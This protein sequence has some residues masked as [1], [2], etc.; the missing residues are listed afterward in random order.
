MTQIEHQEDV[1][2]TPHVSKTVLALT[3]ESNCE[4]LGTVFPKLLNNNYK[5]VLN[6]TIET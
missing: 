1:P 5:I 3:Q 2:A 4:I 6:N